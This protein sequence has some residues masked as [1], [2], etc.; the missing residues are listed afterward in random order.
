MTST[1]SL[2]PSASERSLDFLEPSTPPSIG[3]SLHNVGIRTT[4]DSSHLQPPSQG[5]SFNFGQP[6]ISRRSSHDL[7]ECIEQSEDKRLSE[8]QAR[9]VFSQVVDVVHYLD[10]RGITHRDIKDENLVIDRNLEVFSIF[11]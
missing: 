11:L 1:P 4:T 5:N 8:S 10:S 6:E 2:S 7:F 3:S 9:Y